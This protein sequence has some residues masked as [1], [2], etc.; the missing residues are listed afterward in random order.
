M[1]FCVENHKKSILKKNPPRIDK[2]HIA[3]SQ[4]AIA[5]NV[6]TTIVFPYTSNKQ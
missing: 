6:H 1:V 2:M 4:A 5:T 3:K